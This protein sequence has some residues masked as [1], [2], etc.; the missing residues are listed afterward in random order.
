MSSERL[1]GIDHPQTIQDYVSPYVDLQLE[2]ILKNPSS[3]IRQMC[4]LVQTHLALYYFAGGCRSTALR[5]L[6]R[7]RY[8]TL[9][10]SGEDHPQIIALDVSDTL[11]P[12]SKVD[13]VLQDG[14]FQKD[15]LLMFLLSSASE[16]PGSCSS[17]THG[18]RAVTGVPE[19]CFNFILKI[20]R[21]HFLTVCTLVRACLA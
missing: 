3:L 6:Y 4:S 5:L 9:I 16:C 14:T 7:A 17:R 2:D 12:E 18:A 8:L 11:D 19:E 15:P 10:V 20:P 13:N 21:L 1:Q